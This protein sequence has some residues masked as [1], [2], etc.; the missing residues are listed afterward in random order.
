MTEEREAQQIQEAWDAAFPTPVK[1]AVQL[2]ETTEQLGKY[3]VQMGQ[4]MM[5]MQTR[6]DE[7]EEKQR[8]VTLSHEETK[9]IAKLIRNRAWDYCEKYDLVDS[10]YC[11]RAVAREIKKAVLTRYG[12]KDL[13]DVPAIARQAVE[14]Q[15]SKWT[16]IRLVYRCREKVRSGGG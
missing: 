15:I 3:M 13:H 9:I 14:S 10:D 1:T 2:R 7:L 6:L 8:L 5:Q 4:M 12:V 16:D 11:L